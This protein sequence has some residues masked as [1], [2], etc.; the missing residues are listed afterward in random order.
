MEQTTMDRWPAEVIKLS[1]AWID[2]PPAEDLREGYGDD[3]PREF[4]RVDKLRLED[5]Y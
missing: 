2:L 4:G 1:G 5:W 3:V